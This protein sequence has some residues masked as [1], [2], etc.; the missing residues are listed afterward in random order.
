MAL[1]RY[2]CQIVD[3]GMS[4]S[5]VNVP[6]EENKAISYFS[7]CPRA[8]GVILLQSFIRSYPSLATPSPRPKL[9][10]QPHPLT[11][12]PSPPSLHPLKKPPPLTFHPP[13][14]EYQQN[15]SVSSPLDIPP[16]EH[17]PHP[18]PHN[19]PFFLPYQ[20]HPQRN[21]VLFKVF[22]F[23]RPGD[24]NNIFPLC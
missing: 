24:G 21:P 1:P 11:P 9:S 6:R 16:H 8:Y 19:L 13:I 10:P 17:P 18:R 7:L 22:Y 4:R 2:L 5:V 20:I 15:H 23:L 12:S 3:C 14:Q